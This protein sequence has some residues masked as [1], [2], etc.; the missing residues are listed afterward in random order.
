MRK[1]DAVEGARV[2]ERSKKAAPGLTRSLLEV[3]FRFGDIR[4]LNVDGEAVVRGERANKRLVGIRF[5][6]SQAVVYM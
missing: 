4:A 1:S 2:K 3:V 6:C 5:R